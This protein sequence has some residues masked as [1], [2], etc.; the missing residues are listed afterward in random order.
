MR[1]LVLI[2]ALM[3]SVIAAAGNP[4]RIVFEHECATATFAADGFECHGLDGDLLKLS[5]SDWTT[6][7]DKQ[8]A[9]YRYRLH[10]L[11]LRFFDLGGVNFT[12]T[13][14]AIPNGGYKYCSRPRD[15]FTYSCWDR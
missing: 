7:D 10:L 6:L 15:K 4:G 1:I 5:M 8:R 2:S 9:H 3:M 12:L 14:P 13:S 11:V